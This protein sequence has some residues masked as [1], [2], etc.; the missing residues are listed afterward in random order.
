M[1][2]LSSPSE[3]PSKKAVDRPK[4]TLT[5]IKGMRLNTSDQHN[6]ESDEPRISSSK[7]KKN[8]I[9]TRV[10]IRWGPDTC[11]LLQRRISLL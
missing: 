6:D 9:L 4:N 3:E 5:L 11:H 2:Q 1:G 10:N 8:N 7:S